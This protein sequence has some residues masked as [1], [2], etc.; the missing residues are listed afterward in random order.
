MANIKHEAPSQRMHYR[1]TVP[2]TIEI[3]GTVY[4]SSD[5]SMGGFRIENIDRE[6][7]AD[8]IFD[9]VISVNFQGYA[10]SFVQKSQVVRYDGERKMLAAQFLDMDERTKDILTFFSQ[11]LVSG[12]MGTV[13]EAIR[14]IDT[15]V[16]PVELSKA[17]KGEKIP[18]RR[19]IKRTIIATIYMT[20]GLAIA[21]YIGITL[22]STFFRIQVDAGVIAAHVEPLISPQDG[23]LEKILVPDDGRV[24]KGQPI[25]MLY[26]ARQMEAVRMAEVAVQAAKHRYD[27]LKNRLESENISLGIYR[28]VGNSRLK[29]ARDKVSKYREEVALARAELERKQQ[30]LDQGVLSRSEVEREQQRVTSI[31]RNLLE[32]RAELQMAKDSYAALKEGLFFS[33]NQVEGETLGLKAQLEAAANDVDIEQQR[34]EVAREQLKK[35]VLKSPFDGTVVKVFK[36]VGNT[37]ETGEQLAIIEQHKDRFVTAYLTQDEVEKIKLGDEAMVF[38]PALDLRVSGKVVLI[39]RT[40]GFVSEMESRFKWRSSRDRSALAI[41]EFNQP[42]MPGLSK[43]IPT[44]LPAVVNFRRVATSELLAR[45]LGY[46]GYKGGEMEPEEAETIRRGIYQAPVAPPAQRPTAGS[47]QME[48]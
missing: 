16:T 20:L 17:P 38:V 12:E 45:V 14:R 34:L 25:I 21:V 36:T 48:N 8:D 2:I 6:M 27:N 43:D 42:D 28:Q 4:K 15:P 19:Q 24:S 39:D 40:S 32:A 10:I 35:Y 31:E 18:A 22:Y 47:E 29:A 41:V 5:W 3:G 7:H 46:F 26:N 9:A 13:G 1:L 23:I 44:G 37:V 30:L 33:G 11:G